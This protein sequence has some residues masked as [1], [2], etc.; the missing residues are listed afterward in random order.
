MAEAT[1]ELDH[2]FCKEMEKI[3]EESV[4]GYPFLSYLCSKRTLI[5]NKRPFYL[6]FTVLLT[7]CAGVLP[8]KAQYYK[9][10]P[11]NHYLQLRDELE[12]QQRSTDEQKEA[13]WK[14]VGTGSFQAMMYM[15]H[16]LKDASLSKVAASVAASIA[17]NHKE[18]DGKAMR[19]LLRK[20]RPLLRGKQLKAVDNF[21]RT[22]QKGGFFSIF[23]GKT[24]KGWK[25]L[26]DNP[27]KRATMST[28]EMAEK[29]KTAD[30]AMRRDWKVMD[31][32]LV[33]V[34]S[35][36]DNIC[37]IDK[38]RDFEMYVDWRLDPAGKEP[39]AGVYLRGTPQ[40]QI[41]DTARVN[42][43][44]QV[45]SGGLYN[46][47]KHQS[48]PLRV[49]DN[50]LGKWNSFLIRMVGDRVSVWLN[51]V[52]VVDNVVMENYWD[53]SQPIPAND[54]IELQAHGSRVYFRDIYIRRL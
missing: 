38:Y 30:E 15:G 36:F 28:A 23:D 52:K 9:S 31:G 24:L 13:L 45:G 21:L 47:Q 42:V 43:G 16:Y 5:M 29:Q 41:W 4:C 14:M 22:R 35:G 26:V 2:Q 10:T 54:Q 1:A 51:G 49:A 6:V 8:A 19:D 17:L 27:I 50:Q 11:E 3:I 53:R 34:G 7:V 18:F 39:D 46:N 33:Y 40:V 44:A 25:G 37:T 12:S 20:A 32:E 48:K